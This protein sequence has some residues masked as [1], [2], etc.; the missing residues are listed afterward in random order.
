MNSQPKP[1]LDGASLGSRCEAQRAAFDRDPYPDRA[2]RIRRLAALE[3]LVRTQ[4]EPLADAVSRDFG[5]RSKHETRLL[6]IFPCL[7]ALKHARRHLA[8]WM[9]AQRRPVSLWFQPGRA[10]LLPQPLGV[11]GIIVP[12]NYPIYLA[13]AP[14]TAALAAGNRAMVKLSELTPATSALFSR[15]IREHFAEDEV[16]IVEGDAAVAADFARLPFDHLLFTGSTEVGRHV[17]RA[18]ADRLTPVTLELGG[19]SPVIVGPEADLPQAAE[20]I[21]VGKTLNAGQT[22][23]APDYVL[24]PHLSLPSL[25]A[26]LQKNVTT[27]YPRIASTPDY[28]S[29]INARHFERLVRYLEEARTAGARIVNLGGFEPDPRSRR[30]PPTVILDAPQGLPVMREEIFGPILPVLGYEGIDEAIRFVNA[31]PRPLALYVFDRNPATIQRVLE[32]T[33]AGGVT[34]NDTI[35]HVAQEELPF[36]G[37]GPSGMGQYHGQ[38]GFLTFS[39]LKPVFRQSRLNGFRMFMAPYGQRFDTLLRVLLR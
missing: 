23:I 10:A 8:H 26:G 9:R 2:T 4:A 34:V 25:L 7:Q 39:K 13:V 32:R 14:L 16:A 17:M 33:V 30:F 24:A 11:A 27:L 35:L 29:I 18:A 3:A 15:L 22:C 28:T 37:V 36:G 20:R 1:T 21:A 5:N 12:W 31:R 19:K 38:A 6:E